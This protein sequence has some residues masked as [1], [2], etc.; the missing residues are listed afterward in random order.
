MD[1]LTA[2]AAALSGVLS[3]RDEASR[4]G[5]QLH[6]RLPVLLALRNQLDAAL[7]RTVRH[8]GLSGLPEIDGHTTMASWLRGHGRM[9]GAAAHRLVAVGRSLENLPAADAA[10]AAG[11]ITAD[12]VTVLGQ[13]ATD[14][15][16]AAADAE[17]LDLAEVDATL[18]ALAAAGTHQDTVLGVGHYLAR[19]DPDGP[20]PDPTA[21]RGLT[22]PVHG[23]GS[24]GIRGQLDAIGGE[25]VATALESLVQAD[26]PAGDSRT[27]AQQ[28]AD[29]LVQLCDT[30]LAAGELPTLRGRKP[31]VTVVVPLEDLLDPTTGPG[32]ATLGLGA[33]VSAAR[34]RLLA[35]DSQVTRV[36]MGPDSQP[37]D[38]GRSHR[39]VPAHL[40]KAVELR[41]RGCVFTGCGAPKYWCDV[42]HLVHWIDDGPTSLENS[43]LLCERHH[44]KVHHGFRVERQPDNSYRTFRP[45]DTEIVVGPR[46]PGLD[47][48]PAAPSE[49]P[50][51]T[52][53]RARRRTT[54]SPGA[55]ASRAT[56]RDPVDLDT[57]IDIE[58][59]LRPTVTL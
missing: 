29:A 22:L 20:E 52:G 35:C 50:R 23:D 48:T 44:T 17:G 8:G 57:V 38:L 39:I 27:R 49:P 15:R 24:R 7:A 36:L 55:G 53:G 9:S 41:D 10:F 26:R 31:Q 21:D 2:A 30:H 51:M 28:L 12:Q 45:D 16:R 59:T 40:R 3:R 42:H 14:E 32:A 56:P 34:A 6:E 18:T 46:L 54:R 19:L 4:F 5:F 25:K 37:L 47:A 11:S 33:Q 58:P 43:A 13:I 1:D